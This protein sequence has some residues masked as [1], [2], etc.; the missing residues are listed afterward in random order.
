METAY[1]RLRSANG[2]IDKTY[3]MPHSVVVNSLPTQGTLYLD[4]ER[5]FPVTANVPL[6]LN[7]Y[8]CAIRDKTNRTKLLLHSA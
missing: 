4:P 3:Q 6:L 8:G 2:T 1:L 5:Q 7:N